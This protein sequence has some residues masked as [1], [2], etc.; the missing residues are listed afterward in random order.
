MK[1]ES[2]LNSSVKDLQSKNAEDGVLTDFTIID[3]L[4]LGIFISLLYTIFSD[5]C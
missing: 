1:G 3:I 4:E 2:S 5:A